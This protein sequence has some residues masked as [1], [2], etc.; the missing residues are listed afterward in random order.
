ME[1][2]WPPAVVFP[3]MYLQERRWSPSLLWLL[4]PDTLPQQKKILPENPALLGLNC[5]MRVRTFL[6]SFCVCQGTFYEYEKNYSYSASCC[7]IY[8][9]IY[10]YIYICVCVCV[11][12][13]VHSTYNIL[14]IYIYI[15]II[16]HLH[17][18]LKKFTTIS[19]QVI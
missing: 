16:K 19:R 2:I 18:N 7:I 17:I 8:I 15:Y 14:Y 3:K 6:P 5:S 4:T 9:Y 1:S 13:Y 12:I 10:I 11:C